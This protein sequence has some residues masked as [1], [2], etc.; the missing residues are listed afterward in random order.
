[1]PCETGSIAV[2][3]LNHAGLNWPQRRL[4]G[5]LG[6]LRCG[7]LEVDFAGGRRVLLSGPEQGPSASMT[8]QRPGALLRRLLWRGDLGFAEAYIA[9]DWSSADPA[10]LLA[11]V[12][13]NID[14]YAATGRRHPLAQVLVSAQHWL[15]RNSRRGSRRNIAAHYDLGNA[16]YAQ[17]LDPGMTYSAAMFE[18]GDSLARAQSRKYARILAT[19]A[20][21]PGDHILEIGCGWGGFAEYAAQQGM[22]VTA[23]TLSREQLAFARARTERAGL[24]QLVELRL[25]D[26]RDLAGTFDHIVSIEMFEAVGQDYWQGYFDT[27][28]RCL[29]SGGRVAL[30]VITIDQGRFARYAANPGGFIQRYIFPGGMLPT[31][32]HLAQLGAAAGL[33]HRETRAFG[34]DYADTLAAWHAAFNASTAWLERHGYDR[35]FRR[36]WRYYLAFCEAG[37]RTGHI[38][39][40]HCT[41]SKA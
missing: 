28:T 21:R 35:R 12:A 1:M 20:A 14:S 9:G 41:F 32:G 39:V 40:V 5:Q 18:P 8:I 17:W 6:R 2:D 23:I 15:N 11:L 3:L 24:A 26:Y 4:L 33:H 38:D 25:C 36:M 13:R 30:Q 22:R 34:I 31:K 37:F 16:F 10:G 19:L 7:R 27:L 29:K